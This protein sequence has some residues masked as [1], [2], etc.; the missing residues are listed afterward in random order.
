MT[1]IRCSLPPPPHLKLRLWN[2]LNELPKPR[3]AVLTFN[4]GKISPKPRISYLNSKPGTLEYKAVKLTDTRYDAEELLDNTPSLPS[5]WPWDSRCKALPMSLAVHARRTRQ[6]SSR[7]TRQVVG[8]ASD[9]ACL[10]A[11]WNVTN[12]RVCQ[13]T[14]DVKPESPLKDNLTRTPTY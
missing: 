1:S 5:L 13:Q 6:Y 12:S 10:P 9:R 8:T 14:A 7:L 3:V 2:F 11:G 4:Q